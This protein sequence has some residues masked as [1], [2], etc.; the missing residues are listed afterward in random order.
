[1]DDIIKQ[2]EKKTGVK[3][4]DIQNLAKSLSNSDLQ[5]EKS[6][7][8]LVRQLGKLANKKVSKQTEDMIVNTLVNGKNKVDASTISK[9][10]KK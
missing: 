9:M 2:V 8:K 7:R 5:D 3:G 4:N 10:L 6:I 1:M